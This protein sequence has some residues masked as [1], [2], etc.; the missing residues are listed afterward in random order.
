M[1]IKVAF[2]LKHFD[3]LDFSSMIFFP[4]FGVLLVAAFPRIKFCGK[5][6]NKNNENRNIYGSY[7]LFYFLFCLIRF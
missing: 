2:I 5:I 3:F 7:V 1:F 6:R 4:S